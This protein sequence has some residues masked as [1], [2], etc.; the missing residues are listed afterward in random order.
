MEEGVPQRDSLCI[1]FPFSTL[2]K[3]RGGKFLSESTIQR[4]SFLPSVLQPLRHARDLGSERPT[5]SKSF[6]DQLS[7][8]ASLHSMDTGNVRFS[9]PAPPIFLSEC[10]TSATDKEEILG[11]KD[12]REVVFYCKWLGMNMGLVESIFY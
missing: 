11:K 4:Q 2:V 3:R 5:S 12:S 7:P 6:L 9:S 10:P 1:Q 8:P